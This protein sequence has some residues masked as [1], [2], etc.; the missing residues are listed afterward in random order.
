MNTQL[1][2]SAGPTARQ[3]RAYGI[4]ANEACANLAIWGEDARR[5]YRRRVVSEETGCATFAEIRQNSDIDRVMA[6][7]WT[8]A[9]DWAQAANYGINDARQLAYL[10][11]VCCLQLMQLKGGCETDARRYLDGLLCQA[12]VPNGSC[13]T[14][15]S[16]WL[17]CTKPRLASLFKI[18]DTERRKLVRQRFPKTALKLDPRVRYEVDGPISIRY[19]VAA[20]YYAVA[21]FSVNIQ[22]E[23]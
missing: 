18:L 2:K 16:Y 8:D 13:L 23:S 19:E 4:A 7:L 3:K 15:N 14:D 10:I 20:C 12:K 5:E 17:D 22:E 1:V 21:P 6:R 9:G 11:K